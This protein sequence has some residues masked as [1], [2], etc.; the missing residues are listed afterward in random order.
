MATVGFKGLKLLQSQ[1]AG[2]GQWYD[3][4]SR[5]TSQSQNHLIGAKSISLRNKL[6][7]W[8]CTNV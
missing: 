4:P 6:L 7:G 1:Q 5:P 2:L 3:L 8:Y